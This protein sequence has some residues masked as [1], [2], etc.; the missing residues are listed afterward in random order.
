MAVS[1]DLLSAAISF[2][3]TVLILSYLFGDNPLFRATVY[4]FVGVSAGYVAAVA[5]NQVI[6]P[7][8]IQPILAG[9][10]FSNAIKATLLFVPLV[11]S[12]LLLT[13]ASPRLSGLGQLPMAFLVGVGAA[14][15]IGGAVLGTLLPQI[16]ATFGG[17]DLKTAVTRNIDPALM[18]L[19]GV[20]ILIGVVGTLAYFHYGAQQKADGTVKRNFVVEILT[21][22]GRV[23][24]AITFGVLFAG[25]YMAALTALIERM[26]SLRSF[27]IL[28]MQS[29]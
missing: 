28:I 17:F 2:I 8:L 20:L 6:L 22:I 13:K 3:V 25:V 11:G 24:I 14:V 12:G 4:V 10:V 21:L 5:W 9:T 26:D 19:S 1:V 16:E 15:T 18:I 23:Y 29:L 27:I 7:Q